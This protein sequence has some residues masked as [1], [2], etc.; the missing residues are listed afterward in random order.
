MYYGI[1]YINGKEMYGG[2]KSYATLRGEIIIPESINDFK[3]EFLDANVLSEQKEITSVVMCDS[4]KY[5]G[6][7]ICYDSSLRN[8]RISNSI[9]CIPEWCFGYC[10]QLRECYV[11]DGV[12]SIDNYSFYDCEMLEKIRLPKSII[13]LGVGSFSH[14]HSL[15][16][17]DLPE[18]LEFISDK[19]F[20][21][22]HEMICIVIHSKVRYIGKDAFRKCEKVTIVI[23]NNSLAVDYCKKN[24]IKYLIKGD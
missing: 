21:F 20:Q 4:I 18:E 16:G 8:I 12:S 14:C 6:K 11:P 3:V 13:F 15:K 9:S 24:K 2:I 19:V 23:D 10:T 17:M 22:C 5:L 1:K 7:A